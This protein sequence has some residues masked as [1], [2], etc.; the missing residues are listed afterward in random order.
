MNISVIVVESS[1]RNCQRLKVGIVGVLMIDNEELIADE[2]VSM[3]KELID[4]VGFPHA[5]PSSTAKAS[6]A[7][8]PLTSTQ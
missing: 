2:V 1:I 6:P 4:N 5:K 7:T 8:P 3:P